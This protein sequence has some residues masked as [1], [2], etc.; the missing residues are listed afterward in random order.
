MKNIAKLILLIL[1]CSAFA[2]CAT[3][4]PKDALTLAPESLKERERQ[5]RY[6]ETGDEQFLMSAGAQVLQ[7][8]GFNLEESEMEL[9]V[10]TGS[11]HRDA[12][13]GGQVVAAIFV[14]A[15]TGAVAPIDKDQIIRVSIVTRPLDFNQ[16]QADKISD[17]L[18][19]KLTKKIR[20]KTAQ[21]LKKE[22][23]DGL[24]GQV[25]QNLI[26]TVVNDLSEDFGDQVD[27]ELRQL[28]SSG[29]VAFRVTFQRLIYNT[30][31]MVTKRESIKDDKVYQEFF[32][33]LSK[34]VFL[35]AHNI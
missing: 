4:I 33:K 27:M 11:K 3:K 20:D 8:M 35:E 16:E 12:T 9:G 14:A 29:R 24:E 34:S 32:A 1:I 2:G 21:V 5:T 28:L 10:V 18:R 15:L 25:Q 19:Q 13:D 26:S 17:K 22:F 31:R 23:E 7:D 6:F 30:Q